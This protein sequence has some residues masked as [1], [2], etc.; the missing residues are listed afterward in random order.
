M[1]EAREVDGRKSEIGNHEESPDGGEE[2][3]VVL[4]RRTDA[5]TVVVP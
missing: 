4:R 2:K 1:S 5:G 3:E